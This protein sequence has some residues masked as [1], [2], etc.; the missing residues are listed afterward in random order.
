MDSQDAAVLTLLAIVIIELALVV[1]WCMNV[2][3]F[4]KLDFKEP[5]K[6]E[7]I[8]GVAIPTGL[9]GIVGYFNIDDK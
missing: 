7:I 6:A 9:G 2:Y 4:I 3:K 5:Y 1:G 8:R